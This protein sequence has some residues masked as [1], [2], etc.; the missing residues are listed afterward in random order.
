MA[1]QETPHYEL[2][3]EEKNI[4]IYGIKVEALFA[5]GVEINGETMNIVHQNISD[6]WEK[7]INSPY[8]KKAI[9]LYNRGVMEILQ[10]R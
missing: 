10:M 1:S 9:V 6:V 4:M 8:S 3:D 2:Y 7:C 5:E